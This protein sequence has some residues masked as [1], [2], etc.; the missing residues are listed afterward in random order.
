[1]DFPQ[2]TNPSGGPVERVPR[3]PQTPLKP[4]P[5]SYPPD[6]MVK[7]TRE[8]E[9]LLH[10]MRFEPEEQN[11]FAVIWAPFLRPGGAVP[12]IGF[13]NKDDLT[14]FLEHELELPDRLIR[15]AM[16]DLS[17]SRT[18]EI[19]INLLEEKA[20]RLGLVRSCLKRIRI[21]NGQTNPN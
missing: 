4:E 2:H 18:A 19:Q 21:G 20:R 13:K 10:I 16:K 17:F 3:E 8:G 9:G 1:M 5:P 14:H 15:R 11:E 12:N 6:P 7:S